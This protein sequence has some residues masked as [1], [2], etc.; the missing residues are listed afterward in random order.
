MFRIMLIEDNP[1]FTKVMEDM[2]ES[3]FSSIHLMEV[4]NWLD[5]S[6]QIASGPLI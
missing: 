2:L 4:G 6:K 1:N 3:Q 5:A